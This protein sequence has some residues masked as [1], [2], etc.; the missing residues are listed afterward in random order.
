MIKRDDEDQSK[1]HR[2]AKDDTRR[3]KYG[4]HHTLQSMMLRDHGV[5]SSSSSSASSAS[6]FKSTESA[7][8]LSTQ[9]AINN[10]TLP[11][12]QKTIKGNDD[13]LFYYVFLQFIDNAS[14]DFNSFLIFFT[15]F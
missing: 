14:T 9:K 10:D 2:F 13:N 5:S 4:S 3:L 11:K 7:K 8:L 6:S 12:G 15:L 1:K